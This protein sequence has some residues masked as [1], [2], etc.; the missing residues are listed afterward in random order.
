MTEINQPA[1]SVAVS[2]KV[3][4]SNDQPD[5]K[6][7][8]IVLTTFGSFG[9]LH[10]YIAVG[11]ELKERGHQ[12]IIATTPVYREKIEATGLGFHPVRPDFP[13]P[14]ENTEIVEKVMKLKDGAEF[15]VRAIKIC[16]RLHEMLIFSS[17]MLSPTPRI[18]S[19]KRQAS[20]GFRP[21]S[22]RR[23]SFQFTTRWCRR[24]RPAL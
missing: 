19:R 1:K 16:K 8:K 13:S 24:K 6:G 10:P 23:H 17:R 9:D 2:N 21:Y 20:H 22:L 5:F 14:D 7:R 4:N 18:Y 12:A 11:L 3:K 15:L